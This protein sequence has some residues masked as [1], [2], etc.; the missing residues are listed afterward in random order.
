MY[1]MCPA[2]LLNVMYTAIADEKYLSKYWTEK[3][4]MKILRFDWENVTYVLVD[5]KEEFDRDVR[6]SIMSRSKSF[7]FNITSVEKMMDKNNAYVDM[8]IFHV[9]DPVSNEDGSLFLAAYDLEEKV[10]L[11]N[12]LPRSESLNED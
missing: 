5:K 11:M 1:Q 12:H 10:Y 8:I 2:G 7:N 4:G 3:D 9:K 6:L